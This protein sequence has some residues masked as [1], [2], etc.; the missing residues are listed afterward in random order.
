MQIEEFKLSVVGEDGELYR[1]AEQ[2]D[3][4]WYLNRYP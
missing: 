3:P 2:I 1:L 4:T